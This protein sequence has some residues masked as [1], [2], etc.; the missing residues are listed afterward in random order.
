MAGDLSELSRR[1]ELTV[2][3]IFMAAWALVL[4]NAV[5]GSDVV[6]GY[7]VAGRDVPVDGVED[8]VGLYINLI[9]CH[10]SISQTNSLQDLLETV[11]EDFVRSLPHQHVARANIT[12]G[13]RARSPLFNT[14]VSYQKDA[15]PAQES[16]G[17][18]GLVLQ[19]IWSRD[20]TEVC[21]ARKF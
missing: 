2:A 21:R 9:P 8:A 6:F 3:N 15:A 19:R 5:S 1:L 4:H 14:A 16:A 18:A 20:P 7:L 13:A 11:R 10:I 17:Q 12:N